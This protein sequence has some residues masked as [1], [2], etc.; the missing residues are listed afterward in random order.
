MQP[1][2]YFKETKVTIAVGELVSLLTDGCT[3]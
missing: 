2:M 1:K 3:F